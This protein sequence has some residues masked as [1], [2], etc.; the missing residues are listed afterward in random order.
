MNEYLIPYDEQFKEQNFI[1]NIVHNNQ[2][3]L[4]L[5]N[6]INKD[7]KKQLSTAKPH[8]NGLRSHVFSRRLTTS[9]N[10]SRNLI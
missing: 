6:T 4:G 9:Q 2:F 1:Q 3:S 7:K 5:S 10:V 8:K